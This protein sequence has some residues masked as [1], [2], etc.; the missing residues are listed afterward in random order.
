MRGASGSSPGWHERRCVCRR[1]D[2]GTVAAGGPR[3]APVLLETVPEAT[4]SQRLRGP[5]QILARLSRT[6]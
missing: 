3:A 2:G 1:D 5:R 6:G 4:P